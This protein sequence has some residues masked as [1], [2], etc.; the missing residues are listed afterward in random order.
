MFTLWLLSWLP[1]SVKGSR[2]NRSAKPEKIVHVVP[3]GFEADRAVK[4]FE[5]KDGFKAHRVHLLS[6]I[7]S[8][9]DQDPITLRHIK[10]VNIVRERLEPLGIEVR[11][12]HLDNINLLEVIRKV[13]SLVYQERMEGNIVYVNMSAAGRLT[14]VG[15]TLAG[16]VQGMKVYYVKTDGYSDNAEDMDTHGYSICNDVNVEFLEN[17]SIELPDERCMMLL[18]ELYRRDMSASE[19]LDFLHDSGVAGFADYDAYL[20]REDKI[21]FYMRLNRGILNRLE[22]SGYLRRNKRGREVEVEITN[23]G[24][25]VACISGLL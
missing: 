16:M 14:S 4:P 13:S 8:S 19:I 5:G 9:D 22:N 21:K 24:R 1:L 17:F 15:S 25:Y 7:S 23:S 10:Y 3:L 18:V 12:H 6:A 11:V 20:S 2:G